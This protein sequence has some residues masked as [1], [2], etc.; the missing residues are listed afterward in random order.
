LGDAGV[1]AGLRGRAKAREWLRRYGPPEI[2]GT[3]T[4]FGA[5]AIAY[6]AT[7]SLAV[8]ALAG[9]IGAA[10]GYYALAYAHV[11]VLAHRSRLCAGATR[12]IL[13]SA[14]VAARSVVT[15]FG[16]GECVDSFVVRP[17]LYIVAPLALG[18]VVLGWILAK[19]VADLVFY[20]CTICSYEYFRRMILRSPPVTR[21][22]AAVPAT[23]QVPR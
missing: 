12:R 4:E 20:A 2:V 5:A 9:T 19:I 23:S 13:E 17:L 7:G 21:G 11:F 1:H 8:A 22:E 14:T 18:N 6:A 16:P 10:V 3:I 15:E